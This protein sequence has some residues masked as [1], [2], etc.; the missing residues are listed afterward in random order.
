MNQLVLNEGPQFVPFRIN[1]GRM[2]ETDEFTSYHEELLDGSY[3]CVD[4]IVVNAYFE[5]AQSAGGFRSWW[6][7]LMGSDEN[8]D[9]AHMERL[10]GRF[11]RRLEAYA[12]KNKIPFLLCEN[13]ER[14]HEKAEP[15]V[16]KDPEYKGVFLVLVGRAPAPVWVIER[17]SKK[18][19]TNLYHKKKW[20]YVNHYHIHLMDPEWGHVTIRIC[21]YPPFG[22]QVIANGHE[23]V[24]RQARKRSLPIHKEGNCFTGG[25]DF[26]ALNQIA[27]T[28]RAAHAVGRLTKACDRWLYSACLCFALDSEQQERTKFQY[29]YSFYQLEN[30]RNLLFKRGTTLDEVYEKL[31][32]RTRRALDVKTLTTIFGRKNRPYNHTK[33]GSLFRLE[34][35]IERPAYNLTV[36]K[37]HFGKLTLKIYDKGDRVLRVEIVAHNVKDLRCGALV[38]KWPQLLERMEQYLNNFLNIVQ[39]AH[40]SFLDEGTFDNLAMP[41]MRGS[42]RRA[43]VDLN[44][45]RMR[46]AVTAVVALSPKPTGFTV[47]DLAQKVCAITGPEPKPYNSRRAAYDLSKIRAKGLVQRVGKS[48]RYQTTS[49][50]VRKLAAYTILRD[51]IIKPL[52]SG[53]TRSCLRS[54]K[55]VHPIDQHYVNLREE[56]CKTFDTLGLAVV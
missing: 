54:P 56:L 46:R 35:V 22:A 45:I 25:T 38:E 55:T 17:N 11:K 10:A 30:S 7:M 19:I 1:S 37:I 43:G 49:E 4:R 2:E 15:Y 40:V 53:A 51:H 50:G 32:D 42:Q 34:K 31:L 48:R 23:W 12:K 5:F 24:E 14:K 33:R 21:G 16:P 47:R 39:A 9:R 41:T 8:L 13:G 52:V 44:K 29:R 20:P 26:Q 27:K 6:R 3:D 36:F 28:L 18:Q